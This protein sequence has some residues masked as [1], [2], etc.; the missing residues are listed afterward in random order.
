MSGIELK[1][2]L[3]KRIFQLFYKLKYENHEKT[4]NI[5]HKLISSMIEEYSILLI[6]KKHHANG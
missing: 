2:E 3:K 1:K 5:Y 6:G 4:K